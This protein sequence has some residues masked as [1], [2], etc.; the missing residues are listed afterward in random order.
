MFIDIVASSFS[1]GYAQ[2]G[3]KS[4]NTMSTAQFLDVGGE[5]M[6]L[7]SLAA[8]GDDTS[9]NVVISTLDAYG[10]TVDTYAWNDWVAEN[11]CWVNDSFEPVEGVSFAPGQALWVQASAAD[12]GLQSAGKVGTADVVVTLRTGNT[13]AG[14]PFPVAVDLQSIVAEGEDTSDNVVISTLDAYGF[15]V[16]TYAWNDWVAENPCWVNDSFEPVEG[17]SFAAGAGLWI[18]ASSATQSIR[19]PAPEL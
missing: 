3:L 12:Q 17:V 18:Q 8:T 5:P 16:D 4:G 10:F 7:Q 2:S 15:T 1:V 6:D 19:F 11:P 13:A 14:N 9:D